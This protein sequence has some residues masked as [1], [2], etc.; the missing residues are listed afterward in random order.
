MASFGAVLISWFWALVTERFDP[1]T[2]RR[3]IGK[4]A[5]GGTFGGLAGGIAA[6]RIGAQLPPEAIFPLLAG[7]HALCAVVSLWF[8]ATSGT[9]APPASQHEERRPSGFRI[10]RETK[11]LRNL[12][13]LV[14]VGTAGL[15]GRRR[16][17]VGERPRRGK[18]G[19]QQQ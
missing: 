9:S 18:H 5:G 6:E 3:R 8:A 12:A 4:I 14:T 13:L 17:L 19:R 16:G 7:L 11:Y 15:F 10:L 1:R 2:A